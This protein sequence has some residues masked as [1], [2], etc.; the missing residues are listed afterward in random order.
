M[1][2]IIFRKHMIDNFAIAFFTL[3]IIYTAFRAAKME[4]FIKESDKREGHK[5][6]RQKDE[7][8]TLV[9]KKSK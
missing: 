1:A 2:P 5:S 6:N 8:G 4:R 7:P 3:C 9:L